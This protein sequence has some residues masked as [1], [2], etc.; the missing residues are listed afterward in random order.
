MR[1]DVVKKGIERTPHRS[2]LKADGLTDEQIRRPLIGVVN[3]FTEV[4]P[5]HE[6][7]QQISRAVKDGILMAGGTPLEFNTIAVC[8]GIA[9]GH[10]GM[11]F[12]LSSRELITDTIECMG[13]ATPSTPSS[14]SR[15]AIRSYRACSSLPAV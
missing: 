5:G 3:S 13:A 2:L 1:S 14:S 6:H 4:V 7:L 15:T 9:M 12:S 11:H 8:D 10:D